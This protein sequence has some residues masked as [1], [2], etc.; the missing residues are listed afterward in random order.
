M[1]SW[2]QILLFL[3]VGFLTANDP[4]GMTSRFEMANRGDAPVFDIDGA[5]GAPPLPG[6]LAFAAPPDS[7]ADNIYE[8]TNTH[9]G[10]PF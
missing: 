5:T 7:N 1:F 4:G 9:I 10:Y 8:L 6:R 3:S 2:H